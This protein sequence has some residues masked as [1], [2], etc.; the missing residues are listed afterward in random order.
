VLGLLVAVPLV[1]DPREG[2]DGSRPKYLVLAL[3][4]VVAG[5]LLLAMAGKGRP[6]WRGNALAWPALFLV[7]STSVSAAV[8]EHRDVALFGFPGLHHGL[9]TTLSL[10]VV[11]F[12]T[13]A[14]FRPCHVRQ[15]FETL[16]FAAGGVVLAFGVAQLLDRLLSPD[17]GW[18][19]AR[20]SIAPWTIGSTLG[21]PNHLVAFLAMLL[22]LGIVLGILAPPRRRLV[23]T[24]GVV[25]VLELAIAA[26]RGGTLA[27]VAGLFVLALLFRRQLA[28]HRRWALRLTVA[29]VALA[30][31]VTVVFGAAGVTKIEPGELLGTGPGTTL[32]LRVEVWGSAW[33]MAS[34]HPLLGV[35]PDVFPVLFPAYASERFM[36]L[37]GPF[38]VANGA[39]NLFFN[40]LA[41]TGV[42]GLA[43]LLALLVAAARTVGR[44]WRRVGLEEDERRWLLGGTAAALVAFLVQAAFNV[45]EVA[46]SLC[47]WVLLGLAVSLSTP[48]PL[49]PE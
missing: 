49:A 41:N 30:A 16:W 7:A 44:G 40:A 38:S 27:A 29:A 11:F 37:Y 5:V 32:D 28:A 24:M 46:L 9:V 18:D 22:P 8:S 34:D 2:Y 23:L 48:P 17:R 36:F 13:A 45:E 14:V 39:H 33:R 12:I 25:A 47:V 4:A 26:S 1:F 21:N 10:V 6:P 20:P 43:A 15:V 3:G 31:L 19:W 42:V 35:G